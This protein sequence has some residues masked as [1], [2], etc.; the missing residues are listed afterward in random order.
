MHTF[1]YIAYY[2][3]RKKTKFQ[4]ITG[5]HSFAKMM[6]T[7]YQNVVNNMQTTYN[8][9]ANAVKNRKYFPSLHTPIQL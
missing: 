5:Q 2:I 3:I 7:G 8:N 9:I 4:A 6:Q 1:S